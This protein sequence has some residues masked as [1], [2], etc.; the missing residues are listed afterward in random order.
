MAQLDTFNLADVW[1]AVSD[2]VAEREALV[3]G[4]RRLTYAQLEERANRLAHWLLERGVEPGQHIGVYLQ[5]G[6][7]Y[8]ETMLAAYKIRAVP[9][10]VNFRY[11]EDE[12]RY[13]FDNADLVGVVHLAGFAPRILAIRDALPHIGWYLSVDDAPA[14]PGPVEAL[15]S[16]AYEDALAASSPERGFG[17]RSGDDPYVIYTGGT[18]GMPKG[19][20]WRQEDAFFACIGGGDPMRLLGPVDEPDQVFDRIVDGTFV[21]LPVAP[22][23]HAAGQWTAL[24]WLYAGGKVI[25]LPGSLDPARVWRTV[26]DEQV[27]LLTVVGDPV[28]RPLIDEWERSG[29]YDVS[30]LLSI[31]SG[32][33][34][35]TPSLKDRL[36][37]LLPGVAVVDG[38]GSSETGAQGSQRLEA[39]RSGVGATRF[40]PYGDRTAVLDEST[41]ERVEPG[42]GV[43]GRVALRGRIPQGYY[44]DPAKTAETIVHAGGD[45]WVL[46]GDM[47]TVDA[48][49]TI[50]LLGRGSGCINTGGEKVFPEEV[51]ATLKS[52]DQVYDAI[53]VGVE[54]ER[55]G[56]R[57]VA[58]VQPVEG[59]SP[60]LD[61]LAAHTR[62]LLA[63]YKVPR[64]LVLVPRVE[65]SP[66]GKA[67]HRWARRVAESGGVG[68]AP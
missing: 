32:G 34:P 46:T 43:V 26:G 31:G 12:L 19:V 67:D 7:E 55:W 11:V 53:V 41:H 27:N 39:G 47:A 18:T 64:D 38:F 42:S 29:P 16:V 44:N 8:V 48:D 56:Q 1:E 2:R 10:N 54:D 3:C 30:T 49:G 36:M 14:D 52:H 13:L 65:R 66:A 5:N 23:M 35:L 21:Y 68:S 22:L 58:V 4:G 9:V 20:V 25:L 28:V 51:E 60:T 17:P 33:A 59:S 61:E 15:G 50:T 37:T 45:R 6:T 24:S 40:Q 57:V 63:G 62:R